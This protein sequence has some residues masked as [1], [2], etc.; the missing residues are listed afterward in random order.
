MWFMTERSQNSCTF[1]KSLYWSWYCITMLYA[2]CLIDYV[3]LVCNLTLP[4]IICTLLNHAV[5]TLAVNSL[6]HVNLKL[7]IVIIFLKCIL[8]LLKPFN[9]ICLPCVNYLHYLLCLS[10]SLVFWYHSAPPVTCRDVIFLINGGVV[11]T[12]WNCKSIDRDSLVFDLAVQGAALAVPN[13][14]IDYLHDI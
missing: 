5:V 4:T 12:Q 2:K 11:W 8:L 13:L 1:N 14:I 10:W 7:H 3:F 9:V 6:R